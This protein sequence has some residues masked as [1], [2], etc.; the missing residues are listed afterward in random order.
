[1]PR[2]HI[3]PWNRLSDLSSSVLEVRK[4]MLDYSSSPSSTRVREVKIT[5]YRNGQP[6]SLNS[7]ATPR[8][9]PKIEIFTVGE[10]GDTSLHRHM[11]HKHSD[12]GSTDTDVPTA[13]IDTPMAVVK[14]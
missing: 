12:T 6:V 5:R 10:G 8:T 14:R 13:E 2:G 3:H 11:D 1:M 9:L 7:S 4:P